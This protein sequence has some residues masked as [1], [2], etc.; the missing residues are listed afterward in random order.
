MAKVQAMV[1]ADPTPPPI[2]YGSS[3]WPGETLI[4]RAS[5]ANNSI[6]TVAA[7]TDWSNVMAM[8]SSLICRAQMQ[9]ARKNGAFLTTDVSAPNGAYLAEIAYAS[10]LQARSSG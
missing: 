6:P 2:R 4:I 1:A 7:P 5:M 3:D 9:P 8:C 10:R